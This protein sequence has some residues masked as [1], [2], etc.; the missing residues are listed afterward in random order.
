MMID[1][2]SQSTQKVT[3]AAAAARVAATAPSLDANQRRM[4][5]EIKAADAAAIDAVYIRH[6]RGAHDAALAL[7][8]GYAERGDTESLKRAAREIVPVVETHRAELGKLSS[9]R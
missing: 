2:H 3:T 1:H 5:D 4:L 8:R 9:A 6:Q 7:H